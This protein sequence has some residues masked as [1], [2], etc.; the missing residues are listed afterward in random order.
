VE[1]GPALDFEANLE[2][3][4]E[5]PP[6]SGKLDGLRPSFNYGGE[7]TA[8]EIKCVPEISAEHHGPISA[9]IHLF[10]STPAHA[11]LGQGAQFQLNAGGLAFAFGTVASSPQAAA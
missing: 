7:L 9:Q 3:I 5:S 4:V 2:F 6:F 11:D 1:A 8:C 10:Y